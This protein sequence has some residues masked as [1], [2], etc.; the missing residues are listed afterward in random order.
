MAAIQTQRSANAEKDCTNKQPHCIWLQH[1]F[2]AGDWLC[3]DA[4]GPNDKGQRREPAAEDVVI[5]PELNGWLSFAA[6]SSAILLL[7]LWEWRGLL[8][9]R[10][11]CWRLG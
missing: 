10:Y 8:F 6:P 4:H 7:C 1:Q 2:F 3:H 9:V 11:S 5:V